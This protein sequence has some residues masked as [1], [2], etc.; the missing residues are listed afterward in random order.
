MGEKNGKTNVM[1]L[2]FLSNWMEYEH[3]DSFSLDFKPNGN[4]F[5]SKSEG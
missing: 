4:P 1:G 5:G 2:Y 3:G